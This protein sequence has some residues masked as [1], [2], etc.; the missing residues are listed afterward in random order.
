[1]KTLCFFMLFDSMYFTFRL[2][3]DWHKTTFKPNNGWTQLQVNN[4]R[5]TT[6]GSLNIYS[7]AHILH[8]VMV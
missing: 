1:M 8:Q 7:I 3:S 6:T 5:V 2:Q 4:T